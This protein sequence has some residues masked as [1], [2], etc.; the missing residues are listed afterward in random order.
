MKDKQF[1]EAEIG[2]KTLKI[3]IGGL[4]DQCSG[5][6]L[7]QMGNTSVLVTS[8]MGNVGGGMGFF[9]L[10][11]DYEERFYAAGKIL[12]SRFVRREGRPTADATLTARM[13]DRAIRP[14]FPASFK[15]ETQVIATCLSWDGQDDPASLG[16]LGAS[17]ALS[18]SAMPW[19]GPVA[20]VRVAKANGDFVLYPSYEQREQASLD[21]VLAAVEQNGEILINMIEAKAE[22]LEESVIIEAYDFALPSLKQIIDFQ[23][24]IIQK[25]G[26][27]KITTE[28]LKVDSSLESK[29]RG[30]LKGKLEPAIF[31][32]DKI[33]IQADLEQI[34]TELLEMVKQEFGED[35]LTDAKN[36]FE[37]EQEE[38]LDSNILNKEKRPDGRKLDEVRSLSMEVGILPRT[39]GTGLFTRGQ[40]RVL[41]ILTL[42]S[43]GDQQLLEGM[44]FSG[45][46][47]FM[48]HYN[49]PP[50]S[51]AE[52][53]R[54]GSPG[55]R[56]IGH[57]MLAEKALL[58]VIPSFDDFPYTI[59][60][61]SEVLTSNGST[62]QAAVTAG[63]L[64]LLDAG[65][66]IKR[67]VTG[68]AIGLIKKN[69]K[70]YKLLTDIQ[71]PEDHSGD[72]DFKVA[73]TEQGVT[74]I[75][76]DVK[77]DGITRQIMVEAL[78]KGKKARLD[79]LQQMKQVLD[80]PRAQLSPL[81]PRIVILK[82]NP[83]K[84]GAVIGTGGKVIN[85]IIEAC[86]VTIDIEDDGRV[87][88]AGQDDTNMQRAVDWIKGLTHE[89]EVGEI[90]M[91][92]VVRITEFGA[93][94]QI[95]PG[96]DGLI[97]IS[98]LANFRVNK[99]EDVL[100]LGQEIPVKIISIDDSGKIAL[101]AKEAGFNPESPVNRAAP[102][103][104]W[105]KPGSEKRK[106]K[107]FGR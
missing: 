85:S 45:K 4:A 24:E 8:Q 103:R 34:K 6:C 98:Q 81:A 52:V 83:E 19:Q 87:F 107:F 61:V 2:P 49:F 25:A 22:E 77:T 51:S 38:V 43:P 39:H 28:E 91:A 46:K 40:T 95:A 47:R 14:L 42:G 60:I 97:H 82:I 48:H 44:D 72:M 3:Q 41:S 21:L 50:Y 56:E 102:A 80:K 9:P 84:I 79:I 86:N 65:V 89:F 63:S 32:A 1:F 30:F 66:P 18:V 100:Q 15:R 73:G 11:C 7:C 37:L 101:S 17:I 70:E 62:S 13:I 5:S 31:Q 74:A 27:P 64:S 68:I 29:I 67:P 96:Q 94:A 53:K 93:F 76:M 78:E 88:V 106:K 58:P 57:G 33:K 36:I 26:Q 59:R 54:L 69:N 16:L 90:M 35:K 55:R 92:K 104:P 20:V 99:V 105:A 71:G 10:T 12:G 75:Q 23:K